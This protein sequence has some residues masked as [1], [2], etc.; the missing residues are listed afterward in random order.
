[1][2][3]LLFESWLTSCCEALRDYYSN[4]CKFVYLSGCIQAQGQE[5]ESFSANIPAGGFY[6][7][8]QSAL[9]SQSTHFKVH[10]NADTKHRS[11]LVTLC[12]FLQDFVSILTPPPETCALQTGDIV[13][14][15]DV[16]HPSVHPA[17][18]LQSQANGACRV[19]FLPS[20]YAREGWVPTE[21]LSRSVI[22]KASTGWFVF[23][24]SLRGNQMG[25]VGSGVTKHAMVYK[26]SLL[27][28]KS[29]PNLPNHRLLQSMMCRN[30]LLQSMMCRNRLLQ[31]TMCRKVS[32]QLYFL[33]ER[34]QRQRARQS[35]RLLDRLL[36]TTTDRWFMCAVKTRCR[37]LHI[38]L[39]SPMAFH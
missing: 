38:Y 28:P 33:N 1:M 13:V 26:H 32:Q 37:A 39:S 18:V 8:S 7:I 21:A 5:I 6:S 2:L 25:I 19:E 34:H 17:R 22:R 16:H 35:I 9:Q 24:G 11:Y 30:R 23:D 29:V 36:L 31:S 27:N 4:C 10:L 12:Y 3:C 15:L 14:A 20:I